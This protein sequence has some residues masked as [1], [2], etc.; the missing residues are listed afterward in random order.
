MEAT[1]SLSTIQACTLDRGMPSTQMLWPRAT[2]KVLSETALASI[3]LVRPNKL[4]GVIAVKDHMEASEML[5]RTQ[6]PAL[7]RV[8]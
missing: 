3:E 6:A 7:M 4:I 5:R 8:W 2:T 1:T